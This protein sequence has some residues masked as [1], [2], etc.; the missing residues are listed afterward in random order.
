MCVTDCLKVNGNTTHNTALSILKA[1][2]IIQLRSSHVL[3]IGV[4]LLKYI[5]TYSEVS[6]VV[7]VK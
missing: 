4:L 2:L 5:S 7:A 1:V 3:G 6:V